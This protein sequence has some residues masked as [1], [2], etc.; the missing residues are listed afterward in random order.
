MTPRQHRALRRIRAVLARY[1]EIEPVA[2]ALVGRIGALR[3]AD[4]VDELAAIADAWV[5]SAYSFSAPRHD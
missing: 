1:P 3:A 4:E 5:S 2:L